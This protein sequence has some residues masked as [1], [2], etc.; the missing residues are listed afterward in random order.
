MGSY[1]ASKMHFAV[2]DP[3]RVGG[4]HSA[5][6]TGTSPSSSRTTASNFGPSS[7]RSVPS[8]KNSGLYANACYGLR[9]T[10]GYITRL[11]RT[12]NQGRLNL[13][14]NDALCIIRN[15]GVEAERCCHEV[16]FE[17]RRCVKM[18]LRLGIR[19]GPRRQ[20]LQHSS[21][22]SSRILEEGNWKGKWKGIGVESKGKWKKRKQREREKGGRGK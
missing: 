20:S 17:T 2:G 8:E 15:D 7:L 3:N 4:T 1:S 21:R 16:R 9:A 12:V 10:T 18:H 13:W 11:L 5:P 19:P 22:L 6:L 14:G